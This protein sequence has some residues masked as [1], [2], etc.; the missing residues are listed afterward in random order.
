MKSAKALPRYG[1]EYKKAFF[2][3]TKGHNSII[4]RWCTMPLGVHHPLIHLYT[5]T[6]FHLNPRQH[7]Q[8]MAPDPKVPDGRTEGRKD[9]RKDGR[10]DGQ[11]QSNIPPPM[12]GDNEAIRD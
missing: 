9:K 10:K 4:N 11:R 12:A 7:F 5:N 2:Q 1:S 3:D 8:D 6:M